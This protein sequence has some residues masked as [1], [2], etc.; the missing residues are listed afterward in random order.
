MNLF[1]GAIVNRSSYV[2]ILVV[3][4]IR[5]KIHLPIGYYHSLKEKEGYL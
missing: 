3:M 2:V 5:R 4:E 1:G